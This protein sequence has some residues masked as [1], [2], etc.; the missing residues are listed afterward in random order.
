M[1]AAAGG[2][3]RRSSCS[4]GLSRTLHRFTGEYAESRKEQTQIPALRMMTGFQTVSI[5]VYITC[6]NMSKCITGVTVL[7]TDYFGLD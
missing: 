3:H 1:S 5:K 4:A 2:L 7:K 6:I